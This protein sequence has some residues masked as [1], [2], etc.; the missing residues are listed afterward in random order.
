M[1][2]QTVG[3][4]GSGT[5]GSGIAQTCVQHGFRV[6]LYDLNDA[7]VQKAFTQIKKR[8]NRLVEKGKME[9]QTFQDSISRIETCTDLSLMKAC[10]LVIEAVPEKINIKKE[11]F[12]ALDEHCP[13]QTILTTNTS[14]FSVTEIASVTKTG[15]RV[16]GLHFFNPV[17]LMP[18]VEVVRGVKTSEDTLKKL[19]QFVSSLHKDPVVCEDTPGFIVNRIARPFYNEALKIA[20]ERLAKPEQIDRIM[21]KAGRF[22]MGPFELQ[23]LIGIDV[24]FSTTET[25]YNSFFG[26]ERFRPH[27]LQ[28][29]MVQSGKLGRKAGEG[30]YRYEN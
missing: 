15:E 22:K 11:I 1:T 13:E 16:A 2:I 18:L 3:V 6:F 19:A 9:E 4:V 25:V 29:R 12:Q 7:I 8:L 27:Y 21:K 24:N 28:Q 10:D 23:D 17:P 30:Y 5:M 26:E 20:G 14:S